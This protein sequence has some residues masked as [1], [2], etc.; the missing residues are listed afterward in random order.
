MVTH[1]GEIV[2]AQLFLEH[3]EQ[4]PESLRL[5]AGQLIVCHQAQLHQHFGVEL[6]KINSA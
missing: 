1:L 5:K 6:Q 2:V 3:Y 4:I